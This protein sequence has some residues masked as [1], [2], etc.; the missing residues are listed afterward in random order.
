MKK[1]KEKRI[2]IKNVYKKFSVDFR[3]KEGA[4]F[5]SISF[6]L[7]KNN[8]KEIEILKDISFDVYPG[9]ILGIIGK[10]GSGKSTLLRLIAGVYEIDSGEIKTN[11]KVV[12]L[13]GFGQGSIPKL[14]MREN[15]YLMGSVLGLGQKDIKNKFN[16]IVEFSGLK[17]FVDMKIYQ[18]STGMISR[19][20]FSVIINCLKY[21][22]PEILLF[23]EVLSAGG[24]IEF[25]EKATA[26][27]EE[28]IKGGASV[29]LV[30]H[31]FDIIKKYCSKTLLL[32][33]GR[34]TKVG[35]PESV[36]QSY[37]DNFNDIK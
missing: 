17:D 21:Q 24:D 5:R 13:T 15:I 3:K 29:I 37:L 11:G 35:D 31:S 30:S 23:D 4:L 14:T 28:F 6:L 1:N 32:N 7:K 18:F 8:K 34:I 16:E 10:N 25:Q 20:N 33:N 22:N 36:I 27:M 9:E 2:E 12:Y 26:K 19:L